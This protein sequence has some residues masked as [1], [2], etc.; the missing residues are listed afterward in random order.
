[1]KFNASTGVLWFSLEE[2]VG[3]TA[4]Y[5]V[6]VWLN[7]DLWVCDPRHPVPKTNLDAACSS[8]FAG[9]DSALLRILLE[10]RQLGRSELLKVLTWWFFFLV[11]QEVLRSQ[12]RVPGLPASEA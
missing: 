11:S 6:R 2:N 3:G 4:S 7:H 8:G 9:L 12:A 5:K 1:M 10:S